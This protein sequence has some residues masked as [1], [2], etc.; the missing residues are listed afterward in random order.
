E[1]RSVLDGVLDTLAIEASRKRL[2]L[3][4]AIDDSV[5]GRLRGDP[6]RLRQVI[7]NL[8]SNALK[9]TDH[10]EILI[11]LDC[12]DIDA[13][14]DPDGPERVN[15]RCAIRDTGIATSAEHQQTIFESF[16]QADSSTTRRY[17]GTGL[18]LAISQR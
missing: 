5:P 17:G 11:R 15:L 1:A 14:T 9:F 7:M 10:G 6:S 18:G 8:A 16:T 2:E 3:V 13:P 12:I 4:G